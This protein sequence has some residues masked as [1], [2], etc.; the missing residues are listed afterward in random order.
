MGAP[1]ARLQED[2]VAPPQCFVMYKFQ[3]KCTLGVY[4]LGSRNHSFDESGAAGKLPR[5]LR[6]GSSVNRCLLI[7]EDRKLYN[8]CLTSK[9]LKCGNVL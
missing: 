1:L 6:E 3:V 5:G 7:I 2:H 8:M 9:I 4:S